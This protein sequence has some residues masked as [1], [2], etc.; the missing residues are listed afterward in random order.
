MVGFVTPSSSGGWNGSKQKL[1]LANCRAKRHSTVVPGEARV[2]IAVIIRKALFNNSKRIIMVFLKLWIL[3]RFLLASTSSTGLMHIEIY[4]ATMMR[5]Q[6]M[7][8]CPSV[9]LVESAPPKGT[10]TESALQPRPSFLSTPHV[11]LSWFGV[12]LCFDNTKR[13]S[14]PL[15]ILLCCE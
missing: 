6:H 11:T 15:V 10:T 14:V 9:C 3:C 5:D 7:H 2:A 12:R 8:A 4:R 1:G 13:P